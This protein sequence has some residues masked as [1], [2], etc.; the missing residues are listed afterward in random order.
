MKTIQIITTVV[1]LSLLVLSAVN[2]R[3]Q[4]F[5]DKGT[6]ELNGT[7]AVSFESASNSYAGDEFR[8]NTFIL[9]FSI[10]TMVA[11][12]F[13]ISFA[14]TVISQ[15]AGSSAVVGLYVA[16]SYNITTGS[17]IYPFIEGVIGID[18]MSNVNS[19]NG[20]GYGGNLGLKSNL[21]GNFMLI[22]QLTILQQVYESG[23]DLPPPYFTH[24]TITLTTVAFSAG[25]S[26]FFTRKAPTKK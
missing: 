21:S 7:F 10:G 14:P 16:P 23:S 6:T 1:T 4:D 13:E 20:F 22:S 17:K 15:G 11:K 26:I 12:G 2:T 24:H 18:L 9:G 25:F 3:A 8:F 5:T 19:G